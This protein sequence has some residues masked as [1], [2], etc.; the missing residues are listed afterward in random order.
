MMMMMMMM[1]TCIVPPKPMLKQSML[2]ALKTRKVSIK[3]DNN[4]RKDKSR[5]AFGAQGGKWR[6]R[7][8]V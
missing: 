4:Y 6:E 2:N 1:Q 8:Q 3:I 5:M 7:T